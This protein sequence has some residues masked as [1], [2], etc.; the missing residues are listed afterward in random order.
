MAEL[1]DIIGLFGTVAGSN[2]RDEVMARLDQED[3]AYFNPV[4][5]DWTPEFAEIESQHLVTDRVIMVV[6]TG[7]SESYGS[8]AET[9]WAALS[10]MKNGQTVIFMIEDV[11]GTTWSAANRARVL[12]RAHAQK[13]GLDVY[14]DLDTAVTAAIQAFKSSQSSPDGSPM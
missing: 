7:E 3:V 1:Q 14:G 11:P 10:A 13:A 4:V 8:L 6:I 9:G 12:V 5:P 2:W